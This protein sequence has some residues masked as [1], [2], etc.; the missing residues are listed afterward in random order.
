MEAGR[1]GGRKGKSQK[2]QGKQ[3][4]RT[5]EDSDHEDGNKKSPVPA[6]KVRTSQA[7]DLSLSSRSRPQKGKKRAQSSSEEPSDGDK[8][9]SKKKV[10][11]DTVRTTLAKLQVFPSYQSFLSC[12]PLYPAPYTIFLHSG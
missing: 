11:I 9:R 10:S 7:H 12:Y 6:A 3:P 5:T 4:V 8:G 2:A 1:G